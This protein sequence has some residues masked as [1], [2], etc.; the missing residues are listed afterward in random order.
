MGEQSAEVYRYAL[1]HTT[2]INELPNLDRTV[3]PLLTWRTQVVSDVMQ[4]KDLKESLASAQDKAE[5]YLACIEPLETAGMSDEEVQKEV[6]N[7]A[8][9]ADPTGPWQHQP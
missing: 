8:N 1:S 2:P 6:T 9:Q 4:G 7:C 3:W 5:A